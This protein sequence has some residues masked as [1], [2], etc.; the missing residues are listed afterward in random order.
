MTS[1]QDLKTSL[2]A[3]GVALVAVSKTKPASQIMEI[4]NLGQRIFGENR[5]QELA[6]KYP[7]LPKDIEWHMIGHLQSNKVKHIAPFV[8]MIH[9][10]DTIKLLH[11]INA[12]GVQNNRQI[13]VLLQI[14]IAKEEGKF[15]F[16]LE[17]LKSQ[18]INVDLKS[19]PGVKIRGVMGMASFVE[20]MDQIRQEFQFLKSGY[21][22][23]S[24][25]F[26]E[27]ASFDTVS[28]GMSGDYNIAIDEGSTMVRIGSMI[29]GPR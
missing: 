13:D 24:D 5:V 3:Q 11:T 28:M 6:D 17:D 23:L 10:L 16:S 8:T 12:Q 18:L 26:F 14:K 1:Y 29:F 15:G 20:N 7:E 4:Y 27:E 2:D 19:M 22:Q 25:T 9:A 21:D